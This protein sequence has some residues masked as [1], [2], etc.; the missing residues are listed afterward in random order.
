MSVKSAGK[1]SDVIRMSGMNSN[2][3]TEALVDAMTLHTKSAI[4]KS[5][6]KVQKLQWKQ[7]AYRDIIGK[8]N[9]FKSSYLDALKPSS[10]LMSKNLFNSYK[11][12][13]S[14]T[15][16]S[17]T[18]LASASTGS[19]TV[20]V[21][22]LATA[23][24]M[25]S[26]PGFSISGD[27]T[28]DPSTWNAGLTEYEVNVTL[29][30]DTRKITFAKGADSA[31]TLTNLDAQLKTAFGMSSVD[32]LKQR[33]SV[34]SATGVVTATGNSTVT[35]GP[36]SKVSGETMGFTVPKTNRV[37]MTTALKD[38]SKTSPLVTPLVGGTYEFSINGVDFKFDG[39]ASLNE[40]IGKVNSSAANVKMTYS[41]VTNSITMAAT[42]LGTGENI[43]IQQKT[44]NLLNSIMGV[45]MTD[46][47][48]ASG[49]LSTQQVKGV[50]ISTASL[51]LK[52]FSGKSF[53]ITI[54]G[55]NGNLP[56]T[57]KLSEDRTFKSLSEI[58]TEI[59]RQITYKVN[60][61]NRQNKLPSVDSDVTF[62]FETNSDKKT[63][64]FSLNSAKGAKVTVLD[65]GGGLA[66][67]IGFGTTAVTNTAS[68]R[69]MGSLFGTTA[70]DMNVTINGAQSGVFDK[71][72][73]LQAWITQMNANIANAADKLSFDEATG[74]LKNIKSFGA[75]GDTASGKA[76]LTSLM[77]MSEFN[78]ASLADTTTDTSGINSRY[79]INGQEVEGNANVFTQNGVTVT[80]TSAAKTA[81]V[82]TID[83]AKNS[84]PAYDTI[85]A[86]VKD[87]NTLLTD[88]N[89]AVAEKPAKYSKY[90]TYEPLTDD[91]KED[92][93]DSQ[94]EKWEE[95][96]KQGLLFGDSAISTVLSN[97]RTSLNSR[98]GGFCLADMGIT[99]SSVYSENGKLVIDEAKLKSALE[100]YPDKVAD[101]FADST[102]GISTKLNK[103]IDDSVRTTGEI[104]GSLVRIAGMSTGLT[105]TENQ[106]TKQLSTLSD[107]IEDLEDKYK[108]EQDRYWA[109]F[110]N[111]E[112]VMGKLNSQSSYITSMLGQ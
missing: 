60:E 32:P 33:V 107:R 28:L 16:I 77:G 73:T 44:G 100:K 48:A 30:S 83:V 105:A 96:A 55:V 70:T 110:S 112:S 71:D 80:L 26:A 86:F 40:I 39:N 34:N 111:L 93:S 62:S 13:S 11:A 97:V 54:E 45:G 7:T 19:F 87:Y 64:T 24:T 1:S 9:T 4:D 46:F 79:E 74:T 102:N 101:L 98:V 59:N 67:K 14:S 95:K 61:I 5:N 66:S 63:A 69:T 15:A 10:Y 36:A 88:L 18:A 12:T 75:P 91:Q 53:D 50:D 106:L 49:I 76:F 23:E 41:S 89:K 2:L 20:N 52:Q 31:A 109:R 6:Q 72:M 99:T 85:V 108:D 92:M 43:D 81:G 56:F 90:T 25:T 3:D 104:K 21:K 65:N 103:A 35:I 37:N 47:K 51:D 68:V 22:E 82:V 84:T 78:Q 27:L 58:N 57:V 17:A 8:I 94:I 29:G 42:K 38:L